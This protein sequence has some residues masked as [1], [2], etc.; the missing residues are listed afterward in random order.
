MGEKL[1]TTLQCTI[2]AQKS[3]HISGCIQSSMATGVRKM[4]LPLYSALMRPH[5]QWCIQ[6]WGP[7]HKED[8][9]LLEQAQRRATKLI[10]GL[11]HLASDRGAGSRW[12]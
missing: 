6:L 11:E 8:V 4:I 2:A 9:N 1:N 10:R 12:S 5:L 3:S 7:Q